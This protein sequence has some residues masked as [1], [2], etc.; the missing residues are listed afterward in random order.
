MF[1]VHDLLARTTDIAII[2]THILYT[3]KGSFATLPFVRNISTDSFLKLTER[4]RQLAD[5]LS[6]T[7]LLSED[8]FHFFRLFDLYFK[9]NKTFVHSWKALEHLAFKTYNYGEYAS[10][11]CH[12][13]TSLLPEA[14]TRLQDRKAFRATNSRKVKQA[15]MSNRGLSRESFHSSMA[16]EVC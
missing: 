3:K 4:S 1:V 2:R 10:R 16:S 14:L 13:Y 12:I 5:Q 15:G 9:T 8:Q 11:W 7:K 6:V